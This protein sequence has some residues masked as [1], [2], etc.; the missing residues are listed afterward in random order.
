MNLNVARKVRNIR[1]KVQTN[2]VDRCMHRLSTGARDQRGDLP[3]MAKVVLLCVIGTVNGGM[4][5]ADVCTQPNVKVETCKNTSE[6]SCAFHTL[7]CNCIENLH[8]TPPSP[9]LLLRV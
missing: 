5:W 2:K 4:L 3:T 8:A 9:I 7:S 1:E 6:L